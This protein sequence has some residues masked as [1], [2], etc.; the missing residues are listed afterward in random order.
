M[1]FGIIPECRSA[2]SGTSVQLRRNVESSTLKK[3]HQVAITA[4]DVSPF[5]IYDFRHTRITRWAKVLPLP[6]VQRLAGH[7]DISTTMRYVHLSDDDVRVAMAKEQED[8]DGHTSRHTG[9]KAQST[10]VIDVPLSH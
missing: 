5:V 7:T 4:S 9:P 1:V 2:S 3:Q 8:R 10:E 6:V